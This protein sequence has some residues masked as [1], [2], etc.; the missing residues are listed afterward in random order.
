MAH[1]QQFRAWIRDLADR[2][3]A[4][5]PDRLARSL[6]LLLDG[7]LASGVLDADPATAAAAG[8]TAAQLVSRRPAKPPPA[9]N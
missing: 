4:P 9:P 1:K 6:T 2:A 3:G 8:A 7:G 5:D